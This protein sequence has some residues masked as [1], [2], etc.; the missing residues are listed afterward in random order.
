MKIVTYYSKVDT[1]FNL[2]VNRRKRDMADINFCGYTG[3]TTLEY[4]YGEFDEDKAKE[5]VEIRMGLKDIRW[6]TH[7]F[8]L[9]CVILLGSDDDALKNYQSVLGESFNQE[10]NNSFLE[11]K[12][13][14]IYGYKVDVKTQGDKFEEVIS[15]IKGKNFEKLESVYEFISKHTPK[16][17]NNKEVCWEHAVAMLE[18][19]VIY[20]MKE[21]IKVGGVRQLILTGAPGTGKTY[22]AK[23]VAKDLNVNCKFVQFHPS[24]DY[25]DFVEGL[26]PVEVNGEVTFKRM[27]GIF[28]SFCREVVL[29]NQKQTS[30]TPKLNFFIIDEINR[31]DLSKVLGELMFG[32][33]TDKRGKNNKIETQYSNLPTYDIKE[34]GDIEDDCFKDGFYIPENIVIIGTMNDI[35]RSVESFDFALRRRFQW[36]EVEVTEK[37]LRSAFRNPS[38]GFTRKDEKNTQ[39]DIHTDILIERIMKLNS[40]I[41]KEG[42]QFGLNKHYFISQGH[43]MNL[44]N[45][46]SVDEICKYVWEYR[47]KN[48]L[49]EYVRGEDQSAV[50]EFIKKAEEL[51][52]Q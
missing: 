27:D 7:T 40:F 36:F 51:F 14:E 23:K 1:E 17:T 32:L 2:E 28:K 44:E 29:E 21:L 26:R 6:M 31:A 30:D 35:D 18:N 37:L 11:K 8:D 9:V 45:C 50:E 39:T 12:V 42:A 49:E 22:M 34:G 43:F 20:Q 16:S 41:E 3:E 25:T 24:Y 47:I 4:I 10:N 19:S 52:N 48:I 5:F 13:L 15:E 46:D 33:E 38:Y